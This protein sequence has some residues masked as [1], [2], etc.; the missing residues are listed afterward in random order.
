MYRR[1]KTFQRILSGI[2]RR[3]N[4]SAFCRNYLNDI[5]VFSRSFKE[6][7]CHLETVITAIHEEGL[8]L[9]FVKC[10]FAVL[11]IQYLGHILRSDSVKPLSD[12]L[13]PI[14]NFPTLKNPKKCPIISREN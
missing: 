12:N 10:T 5:L 13:V 4:L 6:H 3:R 7:I 2:I 14:N 9:K 8:R 1:L 11:S